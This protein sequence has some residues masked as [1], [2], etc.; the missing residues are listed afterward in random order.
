MRRGTNDDYKHLYPRSLTKPISREAERTLLVTFNSGTEYERKAAKSKLVYANIRFVIHVARASWYNYGGELDDYVQ[1]GIIGLM[2]AIEKFELKRTTKLIS[3]A[4]SWIKAFIN[5]Y[6][7]RT[8]SLV[9]IGTTVWQRQLFFTL[10]KYRRELSQNGI[11]PSDEL[12]AEYVGIDVEVLRNFEARL[13]HDFS[14]NTP[15]DTSDS[16]GART[17]MDELEDT[18]GATPEQVAI[19]NEQ[20][21]LVREAIRDALNSLNERERYITEHRS[22]SDDP[23][24]LKEVG[25]HFGF[26]RER[27][28]QIEKAAVVKIREKLAG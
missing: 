11:E 23:R 9:K 7:T 12:V 2:R 19:E 20:V 14:L 8:F 22:L 16:L 10:S 21:A 13:K 6:V 1:E 18:V 27:A 28:R 26:S 3:Y 15:I 24:T 4:V 17:F 25:N 5:A